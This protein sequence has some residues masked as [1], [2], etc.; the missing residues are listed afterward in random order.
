M[1]ADHDCILFG[2]RGFRSFE[3]KFEKNTRIE[4][5]R[6]EEKEENGLLPEEKAEEGE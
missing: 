6:E 5:L 4:R 1:A 3:I 2:K